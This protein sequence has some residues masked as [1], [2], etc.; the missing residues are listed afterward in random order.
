MNKKN[1]IIMAVGSLVVMSLV[2]YG[3]MR[4]D[5]RNKSFVNTRGS[6]SGQFDIQGSGMQKFSGQNEGVF[7][8]I[9]G[10]NN[11]TSGEV[12]AKDDKSITVKLKDGGSKIIFYSDKTLVLKMATTSINNISIGGQ[13]VIS[14]SSGQ[15]GSIS[16]ESIQLR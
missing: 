11:G 9:G 10:I 16:A 7:N 5:V 8:R 4:F 6:F 14:G 2:F 15:D 13:V 1:I 12:I 3:G